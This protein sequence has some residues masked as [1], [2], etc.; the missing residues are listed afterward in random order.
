[1]VCGAGGGP[2]STGTQRDIA[3]S[4]V[5]AILSQMMPLGVTQKSL[6]KMP[7][8]EK[9]KGV[10]IHQPIPV[11]QQQSQEQGNKLLLIDPPR[12]QGPPCQVAQHLPDTPHCSKMP[13]C[14]FHIWTILLSLKTERA[15]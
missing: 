2:H 1:M 14:I 15:L 13:A 8:E 3:D 4:A 5:Q 12:K 9:K 11:F 6:G 7:I 10:G